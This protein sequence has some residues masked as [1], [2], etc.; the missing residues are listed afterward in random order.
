MSDAGPDFPH[1][2]FT[3]GFRRSG[4]HAIGPV[5]GADPRYHLVETEVR[6][7]AVQGGL[8]D[9]LDGTIGVDR[10]IDNCWT[11]FWMRGFKARRASTA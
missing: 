2:V 9:L 10:F 5:V 1:P 3:G 4:T 11:Q 6:F 8:P 7:H